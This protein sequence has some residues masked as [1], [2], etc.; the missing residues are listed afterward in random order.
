[1]KQTWK[2]PAAAREAARRALEVRAEKPP[3][4]R[5]MIAQGMARARQLINNEDFTEQDI[6]TMYAWFRRHAV[7]KQGSTWS[8][9]GKGWQ[10]W[11]G[12]GG[13]SAFSWVS[14][15]VKQLDSRKA[16]E[17]KPY[18]RGGRRV[19]GYNRLGQSNQPNAPQAKP[20]TSGQTPIPSQVK[21]P[22]LY[23]KARRMA[24]QK[25]DKFP[26]P[27]SSAYLVSTYEK[28]VKNRGGKKPYVT[29]KS[30]ESIEEIVIEY[31]REKFVDDSVKRAN[32]PLDTDLWNRAIAE[33]KRRFDVYPSAYANAWASR[34]YKQR[35][36]KWKASSAKA[37]KDLRDW[38]D[39]AWVDISKPIRENGKIVGYQPCGRS[40]TESEDGYPKCLPKSK[41]MRLTEDERKKLVARKRR[42]GM[43]KDGKPTM[44]SSETEESQ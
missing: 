14:R 15:I 16:V 31:W 28:L 6:R 32:E 26:S 42:E 7:D 35:G 3:S 4:Q 34:W 37:V 43:P 33:A 44:T 8:E 40:D 17:V 39:E 24:R 2:A 20:A 19:S 5:G 38:F 12:W 27:Y 30:I 22:A 41:A 18:Y 9:Q 21:Y 11:H 1:M 13:D 29:T 10:A 25:Y 36:G 23:R